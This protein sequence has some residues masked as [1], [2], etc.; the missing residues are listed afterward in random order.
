MIQASSI[1]V[2]DAIMRSKNNAH[3][4]KIWCI[5]VAFLI[6]SKPRRTLAV[7]LIRIYVEPITSRFVR[8]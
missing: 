2:S 1:E 6:R 3:Y 5:L 7:N 4:Q 8:K